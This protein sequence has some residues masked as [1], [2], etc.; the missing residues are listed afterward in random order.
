MPRSNALRIS[1]SASPS[2]KFPHHPVEIVHIPKPTSLTVR[3]VFLKVRNFI[4]RKQHSRAPSICHS[5]RSR[6][7]SYLLTADYPARL[8]RNQRSEERRV[9]KECRSRG[10]RYY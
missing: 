8:R 4:D 7:I 5:E 1:E 3:S 10:P 6:G 9:G 2:V